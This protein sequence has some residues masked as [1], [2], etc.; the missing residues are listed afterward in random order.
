M[1]MYDNSPPIPGLP[2]PS[3]YLSARL[4][5]NFKVKINTSGSFKVLQ[6]LCPRNKNLLLVLL[7]L[8]TPT[9]VAVVVPRI[10]PRACWNVSTC[11]LDC[12]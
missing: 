6:Y 11:P 3:I 4:L 5:D 12:L 8:V 2:V 7:N 1:N 9:E 10:T